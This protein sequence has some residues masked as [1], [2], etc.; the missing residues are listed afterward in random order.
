MQLEWTGDLGKQPMPA[1]FWAI[2]TTCKESAVNSQRTPKSA[3]HCIQAAKERQRELGPLS[4]HEF[5]LED[6]INT[7]HTHPLNN[8]LSGTTQ[9]SWHQKGK[10]NVDFTKARDSEWQ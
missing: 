5:F 2:M 9:V 10:T 4:C 1:V 3:T 8:P 7:Q 6:T